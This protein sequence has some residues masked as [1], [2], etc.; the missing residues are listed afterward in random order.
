M[1]EKLAEQFTLILRH[2]LVSPDGERIELDR[3][4]ITKWSTIY[5]EGPQ[6]PVVINH[7]LDTLRQYV[8]DRY[9]E[10]RND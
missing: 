10:E 9:S 2:E 6:R 5:R 1:T 7:V 4:I 3:P 8:I